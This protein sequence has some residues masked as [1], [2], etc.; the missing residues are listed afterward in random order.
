MLQVQVPTSTGA[1]PQETAAAAAPLLQLREVEALVRAAAAD[2]LGDAIAENGR[3]SA[4]QFDSLSAV[5]LASS[6]SKA[7]DKKIPGTQ[8]GLVKHPNMMQM[9]CITQAL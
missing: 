1:Y 3:F 5:E 6:I 4:G 8:T 7:V 9:H 2:V